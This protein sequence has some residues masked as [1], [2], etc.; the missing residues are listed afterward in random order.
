MKHLTITLG[1]AV[2]VILGA[3]AADAAGPSAVVE[4]IST[5]VPG[6]RFMDFLSPGKKFNLGANGVV[7]L[8]YMESC[9]KETITGGSVTVGKAKSTINGGSVKRLR[10]ECD[11][12]Q[13]L[14][15]SDQAGKSAVTV[16]RKAPSKRK[17][18]L[19]KAQL[20][21]Y[22]TS[23]IIS[24]SSRLAKADLYR[25]DKKAPMY[26]IPLNGLVTDLAKQDLNLVPGG[27]YK[28]SAGSKQ[29]IF[30]IDPL[31]EDKSSSILQRLIRL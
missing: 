21:I 23:P 8:G 4:E 14:L 3:S 16:F 15:T 17:N 26:S 2:T 31:A 28:L 13:L 29:V 22:A 19:P 7:V 18:R 9:L 11:G 30:K 24:L 27:L 5:T 1:M 6:V 20:T 12:G 10:V 25:L